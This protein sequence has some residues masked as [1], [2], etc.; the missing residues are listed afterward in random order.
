MNAQRVCRSFE[1]SWLG[2]LSD[3]ALAMIDSGSDMVRCGDSSK[4]PCDPDRVDLQGMQGLY[5]RR[6]LC[7]I[8]LFD[9]E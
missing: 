1:F 6:L 4:G 7:G 8:G 3:E 2:G 5:L 9:P